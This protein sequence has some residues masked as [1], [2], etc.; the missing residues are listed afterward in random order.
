M[1]WSDPTCKISRYKVNDKAITIAQLH[2][3]ACDVYFWLNYDTAV[4]VCTIVWSIIFNLCLKL[5][6]KHEIT[7]YQMFILSLHCVLVTL[8]PLCALLLY[9]V[10]QIVQNYYPNC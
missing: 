4:I 7:N 5:Y 1:Y 2:K 6:M 9:F 8:K 10:C 3:S